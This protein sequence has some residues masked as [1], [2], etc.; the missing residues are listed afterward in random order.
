MIYQESLIMRS[1]S[2]GNLSRVSSTPRCTRVT[3][4]TSP[5][6]VSTDPK[7]RHGTASA[8]FTDRLDCWS[9]ESRAAWPISILSTF[10]S[11][12]CIISSAGRSS[13][14]RRRF[15]AGSFEA[16]LFD[17]ELSKSR[18]EVPSV[19]VLLNQ[20]TMIRANEGLITQPCC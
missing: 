9:H 15:D 7:V 12:T 6:K 19:C 13:D 3:S 4:R 5:T 1:P 11:L 16:F 20:D 10:S 8:S 2:M 18:N 17:L 14:T